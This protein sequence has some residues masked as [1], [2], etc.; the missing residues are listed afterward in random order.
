MSGSECS[1]YGFCEKYPRIDIS[2][3]FDTRRCIFDDC[4][5]KVFEDLDICGKHLVE[6]VYKLIIPHIP[7]FCNVD[8]CAER[9]YGELHVCEEHF[10]YAYKTYSEANNGNKKTISS[11]IMD[12]YRS[13]E[14]HLEIRIPFATKGKNTSR[15]EHP[16]YNTPVISEENEH[17]D[18][19]DGDLELHSSH[20]IQIPC[21][22][23]IVDVGIDE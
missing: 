10:A 11:H 23:N 16:H 17:Y 20:M 9:K 6:T 19:C 18:D 12:F 1:I 22:M 7:I 3:D 21:R 8:G 2:R 5:A 13:V 15:V 4:E 14:E